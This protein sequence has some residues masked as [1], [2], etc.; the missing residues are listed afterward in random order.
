MENC[1]NRKLM[2]WPGRDGFSDGGRISNRG[3]IIP[4]EQKSKIEMH[5]IG[6]K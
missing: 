4:V 6:S 2:E 3:E 1:L 5:L